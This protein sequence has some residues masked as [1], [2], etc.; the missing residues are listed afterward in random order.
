M[1]LSS[2]QVLRLSQH[3]VYPLSCADLDVNRAFS[4]LLH[5]IIDFS[6]P[7][8]SQTGANLSGRSAPILSR[9]RQRTLLKLI[10]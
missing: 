5:P 4:K 8:S 3:G 2:P 7:V 1:A 6:I 9:K 10:A